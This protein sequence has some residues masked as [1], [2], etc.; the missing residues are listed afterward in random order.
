MNDRLAIE[1]GTPVR[2]A[3]FPSW[4]VFDER[5]ER[6]LVEALRSGNWGA[7]NGTKVKEFEQ[8]FAAYQGARYGTAVVNGTAALTIAVDA[9]G[10]R[11]GDQVITTPYT[12]IATANAILAAGAVPVF[13]DVD[14]TSY[15]LDPSA[16][17]A[18]INPRTRAVVPVHIAGCPTDMDGIGAVA[19]RHNLA[20]VEDACQAW[21]AEWKGQRVGAIGSAGTFS[22]QASKNI[23]AGEG[24]MV[25]TNDEAMAERVWSLHNVGRRYGGEWY[26]HVR[27]GWN[28]RMTE[29]QAAILVVQ[30]SR[31]D[32]QSAIRAR[33]AAYLAGQLSQIGGIGPTRVDG[34]VPRHAWHLF[35]CRYSSDEFGGASRD[36]F[37]QMLR[38]EGIPCS[39]GYLPLNR[40]DA[41]V[42]ALGQIGASPPAPCPQAERICTEEAI[43]LGQ[44]LL[45][46]EP[47]DMDSIVAAVSKIKRARA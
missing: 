12:F 35:M 41:I 20:V 29:F 42:Q 37:V 39:P 34:R 2:T 10:L 5:E 30:L 19:R 24:G 23:T 22:F 8:A 28:Y 4:P 38:A 31:L 13:A 36:Q 3:P 1:G 25:V 11:R 33:N 40:S 17:E 27:V 14:P 6:A 18:A 26:E 15:L 21:G 45:L 47:A 32:G 9:L 7:L 16:V 43:W 44:N 46:G